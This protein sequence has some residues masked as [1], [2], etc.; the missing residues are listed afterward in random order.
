MEFEI[1]EI[2]YKIGEYQ[3]TSHN[4]VINFPVVNA[5]DLSYSSFFEKF[6]LE[7]VPCVI[8]NIANNWE[9]TRTWVSDGKPNIEYLGEKYA[10]T[11][12][13]IYNCSERYF[14]SQQCKESTLTEYLDYW[15]EKRTDRLYYLKDWHLKLQCKDDN[16]YETPIYF[17]SDW[18]N[19]Y[20]TQCTNDD[21]RFVYIGQQGTW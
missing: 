18:L 2:N 11:K 3:T 15:K 7:N 19:E 6:M 14:N 12:V 21:Y 4:E 17:A 8:K 10:H 16:F 13:I 9:A 5:T 1:E 20:F